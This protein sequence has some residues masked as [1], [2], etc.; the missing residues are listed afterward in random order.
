VLAQNHL[1]FLHMCKYCYIIVLHVTTRSGE[2]KLGNWQR[3]VRR[4]LVQVEWRMACHWEGDHLVFTLVP[5]ADLR[6]MA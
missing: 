3:K 4:W 1:V 6:C 2:E 5:V